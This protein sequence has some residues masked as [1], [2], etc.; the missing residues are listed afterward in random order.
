MYTTDVQLNGLAIL[1]I[2]IGLPSL[3]TATLWITY[4]CFV[5]IY[6]TLKGG[7]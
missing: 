3:I 1:V 7:R 5:R 4:E 6:R 2:M